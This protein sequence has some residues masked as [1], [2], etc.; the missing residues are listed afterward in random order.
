MAELQIITGAEPFYLPGG[1]VGCLLVHGFT[2]TPKEMRSLG[3]YLNKQGHTV[4]GVRLAGH[5][6]QIDDMIRTNFCDWMA[7]V[8]DGYHLL[9]SHTD[10][11]YLIGL[12]MGGVLSLTQ[13]ARL[14]VDGVVAMSTPYEMPV[15]WIQKFPWVLPLASPFYKQQGKSPG[16]WFNPDV[17]E[18]HISYDY[19]PTRSAYQLHQLLHVMR[20]HL[21]Q[22]QVPALVIHSKDDDYVLEEHAEPLFKAIG[23]QQKELL[24]V[25]KATHVITRDGDVLRVYEPIKDFIERYSG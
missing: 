14:D 1:P 18:D 20:E 22:I 23:S 10:K 4:L 19:N 9:K 3:E 6:T 8:E 15:T 5:A 13:A 2:G 17:A 7:S 12:S 21:P 25:D 16:L 11:I 24:Y